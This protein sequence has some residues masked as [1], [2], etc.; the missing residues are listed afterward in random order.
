MESS[1][2]I[3]DEESEEELG[4]RGG[5]SRVPVLPPEHP[6]RN[7]LLR[8]ASAGGPLFRSDSLRSHSFSRPTKSMHAQLPDPSTY[9]DPY[10]SHITPYA[11]SSAESSTASTRSSAYTSFGSATNDLAHVHVPESDDLVGLG[12]TSDS[13]VQLLGGD[14]APS[15][16]RAP[17]DQTRWSD[18]YYSGARSRSSSVASNHHVEHVPPKLREQPSY[19]MSW[20]T[21]DERDEVG[22]SEDDTDDDHL[23]TEDDLDDELGEEERTS[24]VIVA[25]EGRGL[26]VQANN[27]PVPQLQI[28][29][30]TTHLLI[31]SSTTPN[32]M[33]SFLAS[34]IPQ[35]STTL[36]AL[37]ISANFLDALPPMLAQCHNLEE[38]NIASN[39]LRVLPV[40]LANLANLRVLIADATGIATLPDQLAD[41]EKL[42]T[43]SVRRNRM[44]ALPSWLC[45]LPALQALYV[46]GNPFQGPWNALVEPLLAR[47]P[48]T[49]V[50]PLSTPT[51]PLPSSS[52]Q[53]SSFDISETDPDELSD[54][55]SSA[56]IDS[57]FTTR[58]DDSE[59]HTITPDKAPFLAR[60]MPSEAESNKSQSPSGTGN[61]ALHANF[62]PS[63]K[64][65]QQ[66][67][68]SSP[69]PLTRTRTTPNRSYYQERGSKGS[70]QIPSDANSIVP[71]P[72]P[73]T[74]DSHHLEDS[75][76]FGD[77]E[78]R[79][80]KSAGDLR[81][82]KSAAAGL[83]H[84]PPERPVLSHYATTSHSS[85]NLLNVGSASRLLVESDRPGMPKR[86]ASVG[87]ATTLGIDQI[88][89]SNKS[90][91][92]ALT[93]SIWDKLDTDDA[94]DGSPSSNRG[95]L[96]TLP[97]R[98]EIN[99]N[100]TSPPSKLSGTGSSGLGESKS[101]SRS[102]KEGKEKG[103]RWGFFKKM[104]MGKMRPDPPSSRPGT[105]NGPLSPGSGINTTS[106]PQLRNGNGS[107]GSPERKLPQIDM[108]IS[109]TGMLDVMTNHLPTLVAPEIERVAE[110]EDEPPLPNVKKPSRENL[111]LSPENSLPPS[112]SGSA[113]SLLHPPSPTPRSGRRR[114]FLPLDTNGPSALII[115]IPDNSRFVPEVTATNGEIPSNDV[116]LEDQREPTPSQ[117]MYIVDRDTFYRKE[118][119][120]ARES[121]TRALRSV[122]AYLKDMNDLGLSQNGGSTA[123]EG[124]R[125]RRPT[126]AI[127][128]PGSR[129]NSMALSG[130]TA[131][132][133]LDAL[134][135]L[136]V[137]TT[138]STG[139][140]EERKIKDDKAKRA[141]V[142]KEILITER[143]YVKGLQELN[144]IYI[145]PACANVTVLSGV[146]SSK[147]TV[148]PA[149]ERKIVFGAVDALI[150]FHKDSFLP[151]LEKAVE[152][153]MKPSAEKED[154]DGQLSLSVATAVGDMFW[155]YAAFMR[156][157]STYINNF[158]SAVQRVK[159]WSA[160]ASPSNT[161]M[162]PS[163]STSQ[164]ATM[165]LAMS[166]MSNPNTVADGAAHAGVPHLSS[167]QR[168][169]IRQYLKRCR[170][171]PQ[172][173]QLNLEGYLLLPIQ[174]I[175][176]Y[177]LLLEE[178]RR[179]TPMP[180]DYMEDQLDRALNE[181]SSLANNM[182]EGKREAEARRKLV[183]WQTR[184][185]GKFP[186]P[187]VQPHR[188]L[189]MDGSL[190]LTRVVRKASVTFEAINA[191]GDASTVDVDCLAPEL[192]P[193]PLL[194][195]LCN[196]LL[197]L[198]R[199]PSEGRD[200]N[201]PVD[202]WAVLRMQ[203][204]PQPASIVHGNALR[205]VDNKAILYFDA[206]SASD[207]LNWYRAINL[208]IPASK[209]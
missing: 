65:P 109:T 39:P 37:D 162:S 71:S 120:R 190:M 9:P 77:H 45:L 172:H 201:S 127:D 51:F 184:I 49:P 105:S 25:E 193:R 152:P 79:K 177:R 90:S 151:S 4:S 13:V 179:S 57:R 75:G 111:N 117:H 164:L 147:E 97:V 44:H 12:I 22:I 100:R 93:N 189:I 94:R 17:I 167:S 95:S 85:S 165:G 203:T 64:L 187:L 132:S 61:A 115:P 118:E 195:I 129:E 24:A 76:Y 2:M 86:F 173:S 32:A 140:N 6:S 171:N 36:L 7:P 55:P 133:N 207:A 194:G 108:R 103:S 23:L 47:I 29:F 131:V 67:Q 182:N 180:Y 96:A 143:T 183:T 83:E 3:S 11:V 205:L 28:Q 161:T 102:R 130:T 19:D 89:Q 27:M 196:D 116:V 159:Y 80:M 122:M 43:I 125:P 31:G 5:R 1:W 197:V 15:Q 101:T 178:L 154:I 59:D 38:L 14:T 63:P 155:K 176:R 34:T 87:A 21:V 137:A 41:L 68:Q 112:T 69:R 104:S 158:D 156:M 181:I 88:Q 166:A 121:Y 73:S 99:S 148:V 84:S 35:I 72:I 52:A 74:A 10:P 128:V 78:I 142:A 202:L 50:Y 175:P 169:R 149:P 20:S 54:P 81:K 124:V 139:S 42:H 150:S 110:D 62:P 153:L 114:S 119:E 208:H 91:R 163:S 107:V 60:R 46:D 16:S 199:D 113:S 136:S 58:G 92:P 204:L 186:S 200:P 70:V 146:G 48:M 33:P 157:Y 170:L 185:R 126:M 134:R 53:S 144:D 135:T 141:M 209:A 198:C 18:I 8:S 168:K 188:R 174:R 160:S 106:R 206:P 192:T 138:G 98:N 26:I 66:P 123:P 40:F 145:R 82:G 30:G 56:Q 191:Q